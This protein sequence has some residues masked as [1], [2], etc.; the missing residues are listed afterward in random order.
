[1]HL[2][3]NWT[4][5]QEGALELWGRLE[6]IIILVWMRDDRDFLN[7]ALFNT[8]FFSG[9]GLS[10]GFEWRLRIGGGS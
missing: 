8:S 3:C 5:V 6:E 9:L 2:E 10:V 4:N 1:M 7:V